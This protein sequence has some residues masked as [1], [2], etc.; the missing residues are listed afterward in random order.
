MK[1]LA[2]QL[3]AAIHDLNNELKT[4]HWDVKPDTKIKSRNNKN[5]K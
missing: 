2:T 1:R 3:V 5:E 4:C